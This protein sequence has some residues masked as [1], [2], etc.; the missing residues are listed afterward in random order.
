M[1]RVGR[2]RGAG[3]GGGV[4]EG[5]GG[6]GERGFGHALGPLKDFF[7]KAQGW[8]RAGVE[9]VGLGR[10]EQ[11]SS[12]NLGLKAKGRAGQGKRG[13]QGGRGGARGAA[14]VWACVGAQKISFE[15]GGRAGQGAGGGGSR[16][17]GGRGSREIQ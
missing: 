2:A 14:R 7:L 5:W 8:G 13:E 17:G 16:G 11:G 1:R 3:G 15:E 9:G 10:A 12:E 4:R 6:W